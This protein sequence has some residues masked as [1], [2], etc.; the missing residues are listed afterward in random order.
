MVVVVVV[1]VAVAVAAAAVQA[2]SE[3]VT[4]LGLISRTC[5]SSVS[6]PPNFHESDSFPSCMGFFGGRKNHTHC[7]LRAPIISSPGV[8]VYGPAVIG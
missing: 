7:D 8:S 5:C 3:H 2:L 1:V 4:G 6:G